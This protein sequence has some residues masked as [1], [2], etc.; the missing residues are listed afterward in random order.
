MLIQLCHTYHLDFADF[1]ILDNAFKG[2]L[3][4][5]VNTNDHRAHSGLLK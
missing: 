2:A 4:H 1:A 5:F 3:E